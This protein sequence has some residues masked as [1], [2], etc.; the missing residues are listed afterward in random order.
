MR[1]FR[2]YCERW[3]ARISGVDSPTKERDE[4]EGGRDDDAE[5]KEVFLYE[6]FCVSSLV[7]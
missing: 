5:E 7:M 4:R 3:F 1:V 6:L 2:T